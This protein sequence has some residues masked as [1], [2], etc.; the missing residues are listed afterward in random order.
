MNMGSYSDFCWRL[1]KLIERRIAIHSL[2]TL[3]SM[4]TDPSQLGPVRKTI[5]DMVSETDKLEQELKSYV[6][7]LCDG[8]HGP[9]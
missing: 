2:R 8:Y 4:A 9:G 6:G 1:D 7:G 5:E 3:V